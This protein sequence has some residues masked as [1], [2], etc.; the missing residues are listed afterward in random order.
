MRIL[1][2][3][4]LIAASMLSAGGVQAGSQLSIS[5][6]TVKFPTCLPDSVNR[7]S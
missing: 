1:I 7:C 6:G 5:V 2:I 4:A 3:T